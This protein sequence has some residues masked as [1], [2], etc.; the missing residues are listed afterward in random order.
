MGGVTLGITS[1]QV[2]FTKIPPDLDT[3]RPSDFFFFFL[4][5]KVFFLVWFCSTLDLINYRGV[6][7]SGGVG[8]AGN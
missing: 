1:R 6:W 3:K 8:A 7:E 4:G 2:D 5:C